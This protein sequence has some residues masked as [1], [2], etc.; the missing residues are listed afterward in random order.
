MSPYVTKIKGMIDCL[1][2]G[3]Y[4]ESEE[5]PLSNQSVDV[6]PYLLGYSLGME[7]GSHDLI[8]SEIMGELTPYEGIYF[9]TTNE[10]SSVES[11]LAELM[12]ELIRYEFD[13]Y[14]T[15]HLIT[16]V[17]SNIEE[18]LNYLM[19]HKKEGMRGEQTIKKIVDLNQIKTT[20][21]LESG[22]FASYHLYP[23]FGGGMKDSVASMISSP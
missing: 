17:G 18:T 12:D 9:Y 10:A 5:L 7:W 21:A 20:D 11:F 13:H 6:S 8:F 15:Q 1:Y 14:G 22:Y 2:G 16:M 23:V 19:K 3:A 4:P